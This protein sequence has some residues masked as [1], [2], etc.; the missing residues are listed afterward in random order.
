[1]SDQLSEISARIGATHQLDT[2]ITAMRGIAAARTREAQSRLDGVRAYAHA[3][4]EAIGSAFILAPRRPD[5]AAAITPAGHIILVFCA[6]QGFAGAFSERSLT[7]A[8]RL[9]SAASRTQP[10]LFVVGERGV[11]LAN[12]QGLEIAWSAPMMAH[13]EEAPHVA[14]RIAEAL[15]DRL[16][17]DQT[18]R[19]TLIH[20]APESPLR[21]RIIQR[22]LIPFDFARF[23]PSHR[24]VAPLV[25]L[26]P[27]ELLA[28]LAEEYVFAE[29]CEAVLLS[30]A[31]E[32]AARMQTMIAARSNVRKTLDELVS[33]YRRLRQDE[34]TNEILGL[35]VR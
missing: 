1:M 11:A 15:Y 30:F 35:A 2:V 21:A 7:A 10:E 8:K 16:G 5:G 20:S 28:S 12:E 25:T 19:V 34:I 14:D 6:E 27:Q 3:M 9:A 26:P 23:P 4:G 33:R 32:N 29:L 18:A 17:A 24:L 22:P 31:A 13:V